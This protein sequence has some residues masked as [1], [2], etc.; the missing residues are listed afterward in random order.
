MMRNQIRWI[1][2]LR[3]AVALTECFAV[4]TQAAPA[5]LRR[6]SAGSRAFWQ[7]RAMMAWNDGRGPGTRQQ[8]S[9]KIGPLSG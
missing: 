4:G 1:I 9:R 8:M 2:P 5:A 7:M 6:R 3:F